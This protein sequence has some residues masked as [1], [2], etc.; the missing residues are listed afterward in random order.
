MMTSDRPILVTG[1][2]GFVGERI[3]RRLAAAGEKVIGTYYSHPLDVPGAEMTRIDLS[4]LRAAEKVIKTTQPRAVLHCA[5]LTNVAECE[6]DPDAAQRD[7][8]TASRS[9]ATAC[10]KWLI[11]VPVVSMSTDLVFDG[12]KPPYKEEDPAR[13]LSVYGQSKLAA[14]GPILG[15]RLG[16]VVRTSLIY[17]PPG[18]HH[19]SFLDWMRGSFLDGKSLNLFEDEVRTPLFVDDLIEALLAF[20]GAPAKGV[21]H[22]GGPERLSRYQMGQAVCAAFGFSPS[23]AVA[24]RLTESTYGAPRP[25]DVSLDSSRF[26][27]RLGI[28]PRRFDEALQVIAGKTGSPNQVG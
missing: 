2:S 3:V 25:R 6:K 11:D 27:S 20:A 1:A 10:S 23:L 19:G 22:A 5:A 7:N 26:W 24:S 21:W 14:E 12:E 28:T 15:L 18:T 4:D 16:A 9:L 17:G 8:A 13:P